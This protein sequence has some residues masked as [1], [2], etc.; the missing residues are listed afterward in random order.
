MKDNKHFTLWIERRVEGNAAGF[1]FS[2][3]ARDIA[4]ARM[5]TLVIGLALPQPQLK[6]RQ[7][8]DTLVIFSLMKF[9]L[10]F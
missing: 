6:F 10:M 4:A 2:G 9:Y 7:T 1:L 8:H 3:V 5:L